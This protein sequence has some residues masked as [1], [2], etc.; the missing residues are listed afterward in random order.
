MAVIER[1]N[2]I[3]RPSANLEG[4]VDGQTQWALADYSFAADGGAVGNINLLPSNLPAGAVL[5]AGY[6]EV[7]VVPTSAGGATIGISSEG[8]GDLVAPA[9]ISGA[10]WSTTGRKNLIP[11]FTG[12]TSVKLTAA[13][14][15]VAVIGTAA[16]TAGSFRVAVAYLIP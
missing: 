8:A 12:A 13:R 7:L 2:V 15:I 5:L 6:L 4:A 10:P 11:A 9:A 14:N 1:S 3:E 16:L